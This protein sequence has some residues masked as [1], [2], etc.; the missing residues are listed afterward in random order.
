MTTKKMSYAV[1]PKKVVE[2]SYL[3]VVFLDSNVNE[4]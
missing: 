4:T 1:S 2:K 3:S